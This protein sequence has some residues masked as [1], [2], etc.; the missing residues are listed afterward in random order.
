LSKR[1]VNYSM[2]TAWLLAEIVSL[3]YTYDEIMNTRKIDLDWTAF[4]IRTESMV[5]KY[6]NHQLK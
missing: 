6:I 3:G 5:R 4:K 2:P 1:N